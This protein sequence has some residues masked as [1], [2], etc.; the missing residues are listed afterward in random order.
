MIEFPALYSRDSSKNI[1]VWYMQVEDNKHRTISGVKDGQLVCSDWTIVYGKNLGKTNETSDEQQAI[2]EVNAKYKKQKKSGYFE[3][4]E[5]IDQKSF[6]NPMLAKSLKDHPVD[7]SSGKYL[8]QCKLN[9][10]R[11]IISKEGIFSR[12]GESY[13]SCPHIEKQLEPIF[14]KYPSL[15]LDGELFNPVYKTSLN[16]LIKL[17]RKTVNISSEDLIDSEQIVQYHIYD[18]VG[19]GLYTERYEF[20]K[21][22][23][24]EFSV[25]SVYCVECYPVN[26][27]EEFQDVYQSF[28]DQKDEGC[29]VRLKTG[30]YEQKRSKNLLKHK[31]TDTDEFL[32]TGVSE[33]TGNW[34]GCARIA[35][36]RMNDGRE[37]NA[38]IKGSYEDTRDFL[39]G[40]DKY[41]GKMVTVAYNGFT[42]LGII[43]YGQLDVNNCLRAD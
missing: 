4:I 41:I 7:F 39:L 18:I 23:T 16:E 42:G 37:F 1:R 29:I 12:T 40:R 11:A 20:L 43:N 33:G 38:N 32:L 15:I 26:S 25:Q 30:K 27:D 6:I 28:L 13:L 3:K 5:N 36:L 9:G 14:K 8:V 2:K 22:L 34:S 35:H 31:P 10:V 21:K 24:E 17:V 19:D